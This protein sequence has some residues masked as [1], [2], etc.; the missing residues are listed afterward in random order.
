MNTDAH[1]EAAH[2]HVRQGLSKLPLVLLLSLLAGYWI[3]SSSL[4][5]TPGPYD[6]PA[7]PARGYPRQYHHPGR[8]VLCQAP[9]KGAPSATCNCR[10]KVSVPC[11]PRC[12]QAAPKF[13]GLGL[14]LQAGLSSRP[15]GQGT[16]RVLQVQAPPFRSR[17]ALSPK[18]Q[19]ATTILSLHSRQRTSYPTSRYK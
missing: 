10:T 6:V 3:T 5:K 4:L 14:H 8:S 17:R 19:E 9:P 12:T 11:W 7:A 18:A 15:A 1:S 2:P 13:H 16:L